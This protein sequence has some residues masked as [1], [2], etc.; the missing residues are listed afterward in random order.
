MS[1]SQNQG[2]KNSPNKGQIGQTSITE[3]AKNI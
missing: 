3:E 2:L 1:D